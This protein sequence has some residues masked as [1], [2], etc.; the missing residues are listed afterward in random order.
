[1]EKG[2]PIQPA[3]APRF[4]E[5]RGVPAVVRAPSRDAHDITGVADM[6]AEGAAGLRRLAKSGGG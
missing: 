2:G 6:G 5:A 4:R 1:M 3:P